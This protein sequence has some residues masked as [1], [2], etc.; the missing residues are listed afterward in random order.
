VTEQFHLPTPPPDATAGHEERDVRL[1]PLAYT[2]ALLTAIVIAVF[3]AM[4]V[5][6]NVLAGVQSRR[7]AA[8]SPLAGAYGMKEP[9]E[10]RLQTHPVAD[11]QTLRA[12]D[13][14]RLSGYGWVDRDARL[15]RIPI[16]RAIDLVAERGLPARTAPAEEK[17]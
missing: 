5:L 16:E 2:A 17:R 7:S 11:L 10:P 6:L 15:V 14:D 3:V 12:R 8:P 9:P 13:A 1:R 4:Q